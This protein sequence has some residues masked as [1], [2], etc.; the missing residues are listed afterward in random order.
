MLGDIV[1]SMEKTHKQAKEQGHS[2]SKELL[3]LLTHGI[4]HL[5]GYNHEL[6]PA[7]ELRMRKKEN[8]ILAKLTEE[9]VRKGKLQMV[10]G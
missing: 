7:E 9:K 5:A 6:S 10:E 8:L 1:I 3:L 4:L 2:P